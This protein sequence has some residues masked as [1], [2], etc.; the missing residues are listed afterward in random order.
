MVTTVTP[1]SAVNLARPA[2]S[3]E[4]DLQ[5]FVHP[6][7]TQL[8][9]IRE[10]KAALESAMASTLAVAKAA[11]LDVLVRSVAKETEPRAL[12]LVLAELEEMVRGPS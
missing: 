7:A 5:R 3:V 2:E 4:S 11:V 1:A 8:S 12:L 9:G 6:I 10:A